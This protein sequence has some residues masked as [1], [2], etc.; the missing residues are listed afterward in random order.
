[1]KDLKASGKYYGTICELSGLI[2]A[3]WGIAL[4]RIPPFADIRGEA[5]H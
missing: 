3:Y 1:M 2:S 4:T 5:R